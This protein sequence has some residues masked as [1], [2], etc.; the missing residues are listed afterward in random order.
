MECL[1]LETYHDIQVGEKLIDNCSEIS[2]M[3]IFIV[4]EC[5]HNCGISQANKVGQNCYDFQPN[6]IIWILK[7]QLLL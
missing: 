4:Y 7:Q 3:S 5:K 6:R 1:K 2:M